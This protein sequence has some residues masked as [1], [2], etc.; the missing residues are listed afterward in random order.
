MVAAAALVARI[1]AAAS[2]SEDG[3]SVCPG[4]RGRRSRTDCVAT[5]GW[6]IVVL[7]AIG[8]LLVGAFILVLD[9]RE[10]KRAA[11]AGLRR[12]RP[13]RTRQRR[14]LTPPADAHSPLADVLEALADRVDDVD[15]HGRLGNAVTPW[16]QVARWWAG[17]P[18]MRR[19]LIGRA[20]L[21][22]AGVVALIIVIRLGT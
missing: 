14:S 4:W 10:T 6:V 18:F 2:S 9:Q 22:A 21:F 11:A 12:P 3:L 15:P 8:V 17:G 5:S 19:V 16:A 7:V 20:I 1:V 13:R